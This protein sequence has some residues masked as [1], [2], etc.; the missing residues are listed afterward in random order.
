MKHHLFTLGASALAIATCTP[1]HAQDVPPAGQSA[2]DP[3][4]AGDIVV[5]AQKRTERVQDIPKTVAVA[6]QEQLAAA[7]VTR[8]T[9][10]QAV[11]PSVTATD[12][13][14]N[15]KN[16]G[17]RG[18]APIANSVGVQSQV[19]IIVDDIPQATFST[20]AFELA[21]IERVEV[22][23]GPQ[24]TLSGRNAAGGLIN[25]VT[26][27]PTAEPAYEARLEQ[28]TDSQTRI[29]AFA[30]GPLTD[31][32][33]YGLSLVLNKWDGNLRNVLRGNE[34]VGGFD[35]QGGRI[36]LRWTP[37]DRL[38]VTASAYHL[39]TDRTTGPFLTGGA[40]VV[41]S[42][43]DIFIFDASQPPRP[44]S[45]LYPWLDIRKGNNRVYSP[46]NGVAGNR[47]SGGALRID[48]DIGKAGT[49]SSLTSY[50]DS[51]QPRVDQVFG[52]PRDRLVLPITD[53]SAATN[54]E[55]RY[56]T[57]ELRLA[58]PGTGPLTY[59]LG[60]IY[61]DTDIDQPYV[62]RQLFPVN[63]D[64]SI[65]IAS[66]AVFGRATLAATRQDSLT[67]GLRYQ[68]DQQRYAWTFRENGFVSR[69]SD[70][71]GFV[72]GEVSY[73]HDFAER[74]SGYA[75]YSRSET[76]RAYDLEDNG[77][78]S[79]GSLAPLTSEK[80]QSWEAGL[81]SQFFDRRLTF[82]IG[83]FITN[84]KNYQVQT[85]SVG[86]INAV[87]VIRLLAVG[88]VRTQ[89]I[90]LTAQ[91]RPVRGWNIDFAGTYTDSTIRDYPGAACYTNQTA[92]EGCVNGQQAN[93]AGLSLPFT[94]KWRFNLATD[95]TVTL[96]GASL[97]LGAV[98]RWQSGQ[99]FDV[100]GNPDTRMDSV[101][102][103][104]LFAGP[105]FANGRV[106]VKF[107]VNNVFDRHY[108]SN[109]I[110]SNFFVGPRAMVAASYPRDGFRYAGVRVG[111]KY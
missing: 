45:Q 79:A 44:V 82:N 22:F 105:S 99:R 35:T 10:L 37:D 85:I 29:S 4:A 53:F 95:Y 67:A 50:T 56:F 92:A 48:L 25:F 108:Y 84:Y 107:F 34:R 23:P 102:V 96:G 13:S 33:G 97:N 32:L 61:T 54:V 6:S 104:N 100:L 17:I 43:N 46:I 1:A 51:A 65:S 19:G 77:T 39:E 71:Y 90:E 52:A 103:L 86:G 63:W 7:G 14:Q 83:G 27:S 47:D 15:P 38:T 55:S 28:T 60:A 31:T 3:A 106:D 69:G 78:A 98:Y 12:Q 21:D 5:T 41:G 76:G 40:Y 110:S 109:L 42:P 75:T 49:L 74:I 59:L 8:L 36:K 88:R 72:S 81:K 64:R 91:G 80:V 2:E 94:S 101:E 30:A 70:G 111:L 16:P 18:I 20:L 9:D 24:S 62:R 89:G 68:H 58:S 87:P 73:K 11:F 93:L 57:Q 66:V 26:R